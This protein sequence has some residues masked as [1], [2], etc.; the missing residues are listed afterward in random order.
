LDAINRYLL[1]RMGFQG[2]KPPSSLSAQQWTRLA[3]AA[4]LDRLLPHLWQ[5]AQTDETIPA[6]VK[7]A[8]QDAMTAQTA[9]TMMLR[10]HLVQAHRALDQAGIPCCPVKGVALAQR[11]YGDP[12][13]RQSN[14][15]D[16]LVHPSDRERTLHILTTELGCRVDRDFDEDLDH[17]DS[18]FRPAGQ[19]EVHIELHTGFNLGN[20]R[21]FL[22]DWWEARVPLQLGDRTVHIFR[23]DHLLVFLCIHAAVHGYASWGWLVDIK[24]LLP[25]LQVSMDKVIEAARKANRATAVYHT[26]SLISRMGAA[27]PAEL[28]RALRP[29]RD[30][31]GLIQFLLFRGPRERAQFCR[32][33]AF[34][35][36]REQSGE[37]MGRWLFPSFRRFRHGYPNLSD[38]AAR[39]LYIPWICRGVGRAGWS[40][41]RTALG[42]RR[43]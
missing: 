41:L 23:D 2:I 30:L 40:L 10:H 20:T 33:I 37:S 36:I 15:V 27:V 38:N 14:D 26:L 35:A 39:L 1:H 43:N 31:T 11:L 3:D 19:T 34:L 17:H 13:T 9:T 12:L 28:L 7:A 8:L 4:H 32:F 5:L 6:D 29:R 25:R 22:E 16:I 18:L 21:G 42:A 24:D